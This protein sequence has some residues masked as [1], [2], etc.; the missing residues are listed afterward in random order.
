MWQKFCGLISLV[1]SLIS[2]KKAARVPAIMAEPE[3]SSKPSDA[4]FLS[5][6]APGNKNQ[7]SMFTLLGGRVRLQDP[8]SEDS[9]E[10]DKFPGSSSATASSSTPVVSASLAKPQPEKSLS[11]GDEGSPEVQGKRDVG[12]LLDKRVPEMAPRRS[13]DAFRSSQLQGFVAEAEGNNEVTI[14]ED[15][16]KTKTSRSYQNLNKSTSFSDPSADYTIRRRSQ[17]W[18]LSSRQKKTSK[19]VDS[20]LIMKPEPSQDSLLELTNGKSIINTVL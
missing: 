5:S 9:G 1:S 7:A 19:E 16:V 10:E 2:S 8:L 17:S 20:S 13:S 4:I 12:V 14:I 18:P 3:E 11:G 6:Y 15:P